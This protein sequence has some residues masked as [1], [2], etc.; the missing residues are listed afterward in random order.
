MYPTSSKLIHNSPIKVGLAALLALAMAGCG[1]GGSS[2]ESDGN[3]GGETDP[4][5]DAAALAPPPAPT[6][7]LTPQAIKTFRFSWDD[8]VG[9]TEYTLLEDPTGNA[10]YTE[11]A[12]IAADATSYELV[13]SLPKR[14]NARYILEA[15]NS[16]GCS[17]STPVYVSGTLD[18]AIGY[19]KASNTGNVDRFGASIALSEDGNTLAVGARWED[20]GTTGVGSIPNDNATDAG[21]VYIFVRNEDQWN[22]QAYVKASNT[23]EGDVFGVSV[24]LSI[25]G[26]TLAVGAPSEDSSTTGVNSLPNDEAPRS[27]A[28]YVFVRSGNIWVQQA[29]LKASNTGADDIFGINVSLSGDGNTLAVGARQEDSSTQEIN[30]TPNEDANNS[31]AVYVFKRNENIWIQQAYIKASNAGEVDHFGSALSLSGEGDTLAV[32][33]LYED[34]STTGVNSAPDDDAVSAGAVYVFS[35]DNDTWS[36]QA[37]VKAFNTE[38]GDLFGE[39]L[40]LA[41][42][43]N[44]LAIGSKHESSSGS[45]VDSTPNEAADSAGAVYVFARSG[46]L[47]GQRAFIK[48]SNPENNDIFGHSVALS[49]DGKTLA[50]GAPWEDSDATG[51]NGETN[52]NANTSGAV[53]FFTLE[54]GLWNQKA[55]IKASNTSVDHTFGWSVALSENGATLAVGASRENGSSTGVGSAPDE[56]ADQAGAVYLY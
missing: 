37:Y 1:G 18:D 9:E 56:L 52:N 32:G 20:G 22:Q 7:S 6:L 11:I 2:G 5:T 17:E 47:W 42:D 54:S 55:Y 35:R 46:G 27:G 36:Q 49:S 4:Q 43:G 16:N 29:Y 45:G 28:T 33:A 41:S 34:S 53:H 50:V 14:V 23:G 13:V 39:S 26:N 8:V 10:G 25:D 30:S 40:S 24:A 48:A 44:T 3:G 12:S 31:G 15:C 21:A 19:V 51:V 38:S